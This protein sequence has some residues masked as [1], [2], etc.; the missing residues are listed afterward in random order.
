LKEVV[1]NPILNDNNNINISQKIA[2]IDRLNSK[3][4]YRIIPVQGLYE[5]IGEAL[6][7]KT[8]LVQLFT[9]QTIS[10]FSFTLLTLSSRKKDL[11]QTELSSIRS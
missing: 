4:I 10:I 7:R 5:C 1:N 6:S 3:A 11:N 8:N 9:L 2:G